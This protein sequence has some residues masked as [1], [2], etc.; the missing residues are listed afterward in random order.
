MRFNLIAKRHTLFEKTFLMFFMALLLLTTSCSKKRHIADSCYKKVGY[1]KRKNPEKLVRAL[2]N[3]IQDDSAKLTAIYCW[4]TANVRYDYKAFANGIPFDGDWEK[5]LRSRKTTCLGYATLFEKLSKMAGLR[6]E[7]VTGYTKNNQ[8]DINDS[9]FFGDHAWNSAY[10]NGKWHLF[11]PTWDAGQ[12][13]FWRM[14]AWNKFLYV[15]SLKTVEKYDY[16]PKFIANPGRQFYFKSGDYF[17]FDHLPENP[18]W[19]LTDKTWTTEDFRKDSSYYFLKDRSDT[20]TYSDHFESER[21]AY[22]IDGDTA[23]WIEDGEAFYKFN[24]L[25]EIGKL[26]ALTYDGFSYYQQAAGRSTD[27]AEMLF[28]A[29]TLEA[30]ANQMYKHLDS[31]ERVILLEESQKISNLK[32]KNHILK[33][34]TRILNKSSNEIRKH[35]R[36][37]ILF[38]K[39]YKRSSIIFLKKQ[40][41]TINKLKSD[42]RYSTTKSANKEKSKRDKIKA[43]IDSTE[44]LIDSISHKL[45]S[46]QM[47]FHALMGTILT[48]IQTSQDFQSEK[49][50]YLSVLKY[51]R[52]N[53]FDDLDYLIRQVKDSLMS[54]NAAHDT[55]LFTNKKL[56][57]DSLLVLNSKI[58]GLQAFRLRLG[59]KQLSLIRALKASSTADD[60]PEIDSLYNN[61]LRTI[62]EDYLGFADWLI[63]ENKDNS[64]IRKASSKLSTTV[65]RTIRYVKQ[66]KRFLANPKEIKARK[67]T[68]RIIHRKYKYATDNFSRRSRSIRGKYLKK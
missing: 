5:I 45:D 27:T 39:K 64:D 9:F 46:A 6:V 29:D 57:Y 68:L 66:E 43:S 31:L 8:V 25:H 50:Y 51:F 3:G 18:I 19:Q 53:N 24:H 17:I 65:Q 56:I 37:G 47:D 42:T 32:L 60:K 30:F 11:D 52:R 35:C 58:H 12:V 1:F 26:T 55:D 36:K 13:E 49:L 15:V 10:I 23:K 61:T 34:D 59:S 40:Y 38:S 33:R 4:I 14:K 63:N 67:K 54:Q 21:Q 16:K 28:L 41:R 22:G 20:D 62:Q 48:R 44:V 2:T 7:V